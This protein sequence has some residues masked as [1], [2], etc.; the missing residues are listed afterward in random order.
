MKNI[1]EEI[2]MELEPEPKHKEWVL[3][4]LPLWDGVGQ[5][6]CRLVRVACNSEVRKLVEWFYGC[7]SATDL[8]PM[9]G[10]YVDIDR[11]L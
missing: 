5:T 9:R 11:C 2:D 4:I 8:M 3:T 7:A 1:A 6:V 10:R